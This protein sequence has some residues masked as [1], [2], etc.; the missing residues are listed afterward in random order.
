[1]TYRVNF[2]EHPIAP[3]IGSPANTRTCFAHSSDFELRANTDYS[4]SLPFSRFPMRLTS[5]WVTE[6]SSQYLID[7]AEVTNTQ[8]HNNNIK[9][10]KHKKKKNQKYIYTNTDNQSNI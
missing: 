9:Q 8:F 6:R 2:S 5:N 4:A 10:K 7:L 1:M 3:E